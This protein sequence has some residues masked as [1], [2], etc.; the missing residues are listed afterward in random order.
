[1]STTSERSFANVIRERRRQLDLT[2]EE[3]ALRI[4][5]S[6]PY[7][8]LLEAESAILLKRS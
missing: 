7:V 1:M 4:D 8:G 5:T 6:V 2:Q 3:V